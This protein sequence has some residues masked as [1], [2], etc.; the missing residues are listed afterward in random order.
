M[1]L[2]LELQI[3]AVFAHL[4]RNHAKAYGVAQKVCCLSKS[5]FGGILVADKSINILTEFTKWARTEFPFSYDF[6]HAL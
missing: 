4:K 1:L 3:A 6:Q 5:R 2:S